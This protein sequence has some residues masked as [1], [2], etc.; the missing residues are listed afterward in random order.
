MQRVR[1][2][3][4]IFILQRQLGLLRM[5][6]CIYPALINEKQAFLHSGLREITVMVPEFGLVLALKFDRCKEVRSIGVLEEV[7][8]LGCKCKPS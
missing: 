6:L 3:L 2:V 4:S 1:Y 7:G 8:H 5:K